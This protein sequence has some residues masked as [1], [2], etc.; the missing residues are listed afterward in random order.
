MVG[1]LYRGMFAS[2]RSEGFRV[3]WF[4]TVLTNA[5]QWAFTLGISWELFA[6]THSSLWVGAAMFATLVPSVF[7]SPV[8]GVLADRVRRRDL[9]FLSILLGAMTS[10]C[11]AA[12]ITGRAGSIWLLLLLAL[13]FG[14]ASAVRRVAS[15]A[16]LPGLVARADLL[17]AISL[18]AVAQRGT[19]L[20]GPALA[21][22]LLAALGPGA[23]FWFVAVLLGGSLLLVCAIARPAGGPAAPGAGLLRPMAEGF[24]YIRCRPT[25]RMLVVLVAWHCSLTMAYLGIL[26][27]F[28]RTELRAGAPFY[29]LLISL[30]GLG[31]IVGTLGLTLV[32]D[33]HRRG[34]LF[35]V[36][37][38]LSGLSLLA[39][40]LAR[41]H[42]LAALA[43]VV[44][45]AS[46]AMFMTISLAYVQIEVLDA[47]RG[48]VV[49]VYLV[50]AAGVMSLGNWAFGALGTVVP[51]G[52]IM[53]VLGGAFV[54]VVLGYSVAS[55]PFRTISR[56][57]WTAPASI[58]EA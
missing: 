57:L 14:T 23:L 24:A 11:L 44:V 43:I 29:G 15:N 5:A 22:P 38:V 28:V 40:G 30:V 17:N 20:V 41:D 13:A 4:L 47:V 55:A 34:E 16:L 37:A 39:L 31:A 50:L 6:R 36:T 48:R 3:F 56:G 12:A 45:G 46:Q 32:S 9:L 58:G 35:W 2:L 8:A 51:P 54:V 1:T 21:S 18:Q 27:T 10:A 33:E 52:V 7:G 26:P 42:L 19:E 49:G 53:A 25:I